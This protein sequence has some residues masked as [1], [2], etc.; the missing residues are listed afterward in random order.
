MD[1]WKPQSTEQA[2]KIRQG[3]SSAIPAPATWF[4]E[5][6]ASQEPSGGVG[7]IQM[8]LLDLLFL[9]RWQKIAAEW[10]QFGEEGPLS[11]TSDPWLLILRG[12]IDS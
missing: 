3:A 9:G 2:P 8:L 5:S 1:A 11:M 7:E 10:Q 4:S 6:R 12:P